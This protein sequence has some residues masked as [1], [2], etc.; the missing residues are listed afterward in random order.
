VTELLCGTSGFSYKEWK[1]RFYPEKLPAR[2]MLAFYSSRLPAVEIN[3]TFYR[4]PQKSLIDGWR[5]QVPDHFRFVIKAPRRISH[6]KR[7]KDCED[8]TA[9]LCSVVDGLGERLGAVLV[10]LPPHFRIDV[11]RLESFLSLVPEAI[12]VA[13]EFRHD[14]WRDEA[15]FDALKRHGAAW[16]T[17]DNGDGGTPDELPRTASWTYLRLRAASYDAARLRAW[18]RRC[19]SF[20]RAFVFFKHED[21]AAGPA[22]AEHM[23]KLA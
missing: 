17:A 19:K 18:R 10:Q 20:D 12:P 6:L 1:G 8:E 2:E 11:E 9:R 3:N 5:E 7:L 15:V 22:F 23:Q 13:V 21:E 4:L 14:S 16:V